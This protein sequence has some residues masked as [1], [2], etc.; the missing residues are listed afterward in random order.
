MYIGVKYF[1][2]Q[3][4]KHLQ[5]RCRERY[6]ELNISGVVWGLGFG[7]LLRLS[8]RTCPLITGEVTPRPHKINFLRNCHAAFNKDKTVFIKITYKSDKN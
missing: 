6:T 8:K 3:S 5:K 1:P 7:G 4:P 2:T